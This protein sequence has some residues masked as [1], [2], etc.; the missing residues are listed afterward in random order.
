V[1]LAGC[2]FKADRPASCVLAGRERLSFA[3]AI[4]PLDRSVCDPT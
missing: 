3:T 1:W 2:R 4:A